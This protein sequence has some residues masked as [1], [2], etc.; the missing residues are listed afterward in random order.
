MSDIRSLAHADQIV[1]TP[2]RRPCLGKQMVANDVDAVEHL[3]EQVGDEE[4]LEGKAGSSSRP[5]AG[6]RLLAITFP[7]GRMRLQ[8]ERG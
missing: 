5:S 4:V 6:D 3:S 2:A 1:D 8:S 7:L